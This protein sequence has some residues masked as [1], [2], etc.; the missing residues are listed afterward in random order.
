MAQSLDPEAVDLV[1]VLSIE[2]GVGDPDVLQARLAAHQRAVSMP[3][4]LTHIG[5]EDEP[6]PKAAYWLLNLAA[7]ESGRAITPP[8]IPQV[9]GQAFVYGKQTGRDTR[10]ALATYRTPLAEAKAAALKAAGLELAADALADLARPHG[11]QRLDDEAGEGL[12]S[13][14]EK[15]KPAWYP[16]LDR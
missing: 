2:F 4:D 10:L 3:I 7:P 5:S 11:L 1:D 14:L 13:F 6:P 16:G 9:V 12:Q 15:R 8:E